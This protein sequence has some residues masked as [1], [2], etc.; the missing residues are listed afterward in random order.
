[1]AVQR[2]STRNA[3]FQQLQ[4]LLNNRTKRGR[5]KEF[6]V[7]GVRPITMAVEHGWTIRSLLYDASRPLSRWAEDLLRRVGAERVAMAPQLLA[8]LS[9]KV[10]GA[11]EVLA[12][13]EMAPD[14]LSR[15]KVH[16]TSSVWSSTGRP[17]PA[18]SAASCGQ[19]TRSAP[20]GSS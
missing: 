12:V 7:Q 4:T 14:S 3:R 17:N 1:M 6:L 19:P 10:D 8:E 20:T 15:I 18:T 9:E 11:A 5:A 13:V 2:I 16:T